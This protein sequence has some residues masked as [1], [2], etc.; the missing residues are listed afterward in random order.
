MDEEI[1]LIGRTPSLIKL[2][3]DVRESLIVQS[4]SIYEYILDKFFAIIVVAMLILAFLVFSNQEMF[5]YVFSSGVT[6]A[7]VAD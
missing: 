6:E 3:D 4:P 7:P 2:N 5:K 1:S